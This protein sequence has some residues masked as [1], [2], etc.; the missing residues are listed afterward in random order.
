[1][2]CETCGMDGQ[3]EL[4]VCLQNLRRQLAALQAIV[5]KLPVT[6]DG[7][8]VVPGT[9]LWYWC[10]GRAHRCVSNDPLAS[11]GDGTF[12]V[13]QGDY[14]STPEAA[15]SANQPTNNRPAR[16]VATDQTTAR[17]RRSSTAGRIRR[18]Q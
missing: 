17:Q 5:S 3:H 15:A 11:D 9:E 6:A 13:I 1:M 18:S 16:T 2:N 12:G 14:Y 7:V 10:N 8:P 4:G